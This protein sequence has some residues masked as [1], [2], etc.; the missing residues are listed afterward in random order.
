MGDNITT[1]IHCKEMVGFIHK[2]V[3][4]TSYVYLIQR[5]KMCPHANGPRQDIPGPLPSASLWAFGSILF[6][7]NIMGEAEISL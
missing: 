7:G 5:L 1:L 6:T 2:V 3:L 4:V